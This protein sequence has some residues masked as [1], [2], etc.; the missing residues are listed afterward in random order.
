VVGSYR[1]AQNASE[2]S[3]IAGGVTKLFPPLSVFL[4]KSPSR[5]RELQGRLTAK[6]P[7]W[8][9]KKE[10]NERYALRA[11][12]LDGYVAESGGIPCGL[13]LLKPISPVRAEIHWLG[14]DPGRHRSGVGRALVDSIAEDCRRRNLRRLFVA[15]LHP[16]VLYEPF[17]RTRRFYEAMG[18]A[19]VLEEHF[20]A[21]PGSPMAYY[22][23]LL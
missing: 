14:V 8:F 5:K 7:E 11:E 10:S 4:E 13:L 23:K 1:L 20:M 18:F 16:S 17:Q 15:T 2:E 12:T 6:L 21:D 3:R 19:F 9:G 22:L